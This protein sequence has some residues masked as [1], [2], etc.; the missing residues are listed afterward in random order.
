MGI[1]M[2]QITKEFHI[3]DVL[4]VITRRS[5]PPNGMGGC[6]NLLSFMT[7]DKI[8][9]HELCGAADRFDSYLIKQFPQLSTFKMQEAVEEFDHMIAAVA[10]K[11][12]PAKK[13]I[14][15]YWLEKQLG[16]HG[17]M[18]AVR[19]IPKRVMKEFHRGKRERLAQR[20]AEVREFCS[21]K[22]VKVVK[23]CVQP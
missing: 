5:F 4:G 14:A 19:P 1:G 9:A 15:R 2:K 7:G 13:L 10:D 22:S 11:G 6:M 17:E 23:M 18:L 8:G 21:G 20:E 12:E 3:G 16:Q